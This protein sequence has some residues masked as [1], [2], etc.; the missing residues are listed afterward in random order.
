MKTCS[1]IIYR[2]AILV[3]T[4]IIIWNVTYYTLSTD[5]QEHRFGFVTEVARIFRF[6][7][8]FSLPFLLFLISEI[9]KFNKRKE[10][11]LR[12]AA[13]IL[14]VLVTLLVVTLI[15]FNLKF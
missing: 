4:L 14:T 12:K 1:Y 11:K 9:Y 10:F 3:S 15:Y 6:S 13:I 2:I 7:L 5:I 8:I